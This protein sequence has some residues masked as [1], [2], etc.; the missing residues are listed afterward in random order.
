MSKQFL[1][2]IFIYIIYASEVS[3]GMIINIWR[4]CL[5]LYV[6]KYLSASF[7]II[8]YDLWLII[9][10]KFCPTITWTC[11]ATVARIARVHAWT[12]LPNWRNNNGKYWVS[13]L[14]PPSLKILV[15]LMQNKDQNHLH[16]ISALLYWL[17]AAL[18]SNQFM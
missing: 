10:S 7:L 8:L 12:R 14:L 15:I 5:S 16:P 18:F 9:I 17:V 11:F 4:G 6:V 1:C 13:Y 2:F 3:L